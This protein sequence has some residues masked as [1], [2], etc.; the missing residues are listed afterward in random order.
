MMKIVTVS[1]D[2]TVHVGILKGMTGSVTSYDADT[3]M[4]EI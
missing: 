3:G 4:A 1:A 2:A